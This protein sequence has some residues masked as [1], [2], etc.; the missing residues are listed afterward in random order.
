LHDFGQKSEL[1]RFKEKIQK[2]EEHAEFKAKYGTDGSGISTVLPLHKPTEKPPGWKPVQLPNR[3]KRS[4]SAVLRAMAS[5]VGKDDTA[6]AYQFHDDPYLIPYNSMRKIDYV[7]SKDSGRKA[8]RYVLDRHPEL[9]EKNLIE[10]QP[11]I[12]AFMPRLQVT[13]KNANVE[14]LANFVDSFSVPQAIETYKHLQNKGEAGIEPELKQKLL[15]LVCYHN[16]REALDEDFFR[17]QWQMT[18]DPDADLWAKNTE[19]VAESIL[20]EILE[21][22]DLDQKA[23]IKANLTLACA[24]AKFNL[25]PHMCSHID[26]AY[27]SAKEAAMEAAAGDDVTGDLLDL[28]VFNAVIQRYARNTSG[29]E[30]PMGKA[31]EVLADM[32][33]FKV[34]PDQQT[35][36]N[37]LSLLSTLSAK[38]RQMQGRNNGNVYLEEAMAALNE[39]R[40]VLGVE[41]SLGAYLH[42]AK[43]NPMAIYDVI[44]ILEKAE[45]EANKDHPVFEVKTPADFDFFLEAV[46]FVRM[47][48]ISWAY[49]LHALAV[50]HPEF[51]GGF[52]SQNFYHQQLMYHGWRRSPSTWPCGC[53]SGWCPT[54]SPPTSASTRTSSRNSTPNRAS[55]TW[56]GSGQTCRQATCCRRG[57]GVGWKFTTR[58]CRPW[59][60]RRT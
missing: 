15:E 34:K 41:P 52:N 32:K 5:V 16:E 47:A 30:D 42:V 28:N 58:F 33:T 12:K 48:D 39:F 10:M 56:P 51:L 35:L 21:D 11:K 1:V 36:V 54:P 27:R 55:S 53:T 13:E 6:P 19:A 37:Y 25:T 49:R 22:A 14:L 46:G 4:P 29:V 17:E 2:L 31:K 18:T 26:E 50:S 7:L 8:A 59:R 20:N 45:A 57:L 60:R 3:I 40:N 9:F 44:E 38:N 43:I 24:Y 23:K